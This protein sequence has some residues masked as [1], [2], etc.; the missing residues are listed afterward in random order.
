M[1][2]EIWECSPF[3]GDRK[4]L[5]AEYSNRGHAV[6]KIRGLVNR[7]WRSASAYELGADPTWPAI[8]YR[9]VTHCPREPFTGRR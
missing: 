3:T 4:R 7:Q 8:V 2:Y 1:I 9:L 5:V 6:A